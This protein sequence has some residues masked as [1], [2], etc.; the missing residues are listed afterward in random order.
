MSFYSKG[1]TRLENTDCLAGRDIFTLS[2][3]EHPNY[4]TCK[5]WCS[6]KNTCTAFAVNGGSCYFKNWNCQ[7]NQYE[8]SGVT[9]FI[10]T[11]KAKEIK[12]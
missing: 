9:T 12:A 7:R 10:K 11:S 4:E 3:N 5:R 2:S 6:T 1:Y 8:L